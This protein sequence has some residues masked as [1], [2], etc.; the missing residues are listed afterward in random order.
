[1]RLLRGLGTDIPGVAQ[2]GPPGSFRA[3]PREA[4]TGRRSWPLPLGDPGIQ[5]PPPPDPESSAFSS[6][7]WGSSPVFLPTP[8]VP[9]PSS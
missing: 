1:M 5:S 8:G 7:M 9:A 6:L 2:H 4:P 3:P